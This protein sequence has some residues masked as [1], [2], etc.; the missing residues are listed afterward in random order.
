MVCAPEEVVRESTR[1]RAS[2]AFAVRRAQIEMNS[3]MSEATPP[4]TFSTFSASIVERDLAR[5]RSRGQEEPWAAFKRQGNRRV[6]GLP[7][8]R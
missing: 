8:R 4:A 6:R 3:E 2:T 1:M 7:C 5:C